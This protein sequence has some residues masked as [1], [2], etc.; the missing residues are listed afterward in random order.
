MKTKNILKKFMLMAVVL[1]CTFTVMSCEEIGDGNRIAQKQQ[2]QINLNAVRSVEIPQ[3][4]Q[5]AERATVARWTKIWDSTTKPCYVYLFVPGVGCIGYYISS[6]KPASSRNYLVPEYT[7]KSTGNGAVI[8]TQQPDLDGTYGD[9]N[10]GIRFFTASGSAVEY[11]GSSF[12]YVYSDT[13]LNI[14]V[15]CLGQ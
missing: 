3:V 5:F 8:N 6:G 10:P 4:T 9:N 15:P 14:K 13:K 11:G 1:A 2:E 7:E 12:A